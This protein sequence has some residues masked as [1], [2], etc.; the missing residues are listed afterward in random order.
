MKKVWEFIKLHFAKNF[1]WVLFVLS[2]V[3]FVVFHGFIKGAATV[4][5]FWTGLECYKYYFNK[6]T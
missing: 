3:L 2:A 1:R 6:K 5:F 4:G